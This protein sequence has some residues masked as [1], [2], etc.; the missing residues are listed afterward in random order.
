LEFTKKGT[1]GL[2]REAREATEKEISEID[3]IAS[4]LLGL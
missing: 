2:R 3:K 4:Q 1:A